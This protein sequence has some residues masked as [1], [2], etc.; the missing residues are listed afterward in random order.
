MILRFNCGPFADM[1]TSPGLVLSSSSNCP[2]VWMGGKMWTAAYVSRKC[3][4]LFANICIEMSAKP[5]RL[6][7]ILGCVLSSSRS[8]RKRGSQHM[9][10][11]VAEQRTETQCVEVRFLREAAAA[12]QKVFSS[13]PT[14]VDEETRCLGRNSISI[15]MEITHSCNKPRECW[16]MPWTIIMYYLYHQLVCTN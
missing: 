2:A 1:H 11:R 3:V 5:S 9:C 15:L 7:M 8:P 14:P 4:N 16:I 6:Q 12:R 10:I 13:L